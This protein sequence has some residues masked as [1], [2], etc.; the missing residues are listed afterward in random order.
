MSPRPL[1][2]SSEK[3]ETSA[4]NSRL[5]A[6]A[7]ATPKYEM[8]QADIEALGEAIFKNRAAEFD[9]MRGIYTNAGID[10]RYSCVELDWYA[11]EHSW[12]ERNNLYIENAVSLLRQSALAC[13]A[14]AGLEPADVDG[15]V[16]V[17]TTGVA[18]PSLD[19]LLMNELPFRNDLQRLPIFGLGCAGGVL[20]LGRAATLAKAQP[21]SHW[22]VLV[23][24]LCG[25]TF[26]NQDK[27]KSNIVA[28][29]LF[30][31]GAAAALISSAGDGPEI[32]NSGEH[33]WPGTLD[34][35]GW[36]LKDDGF[37]V[38]FHRD[39]PDLVRRDM[40]GAVLDFLNRTGLTLS[41]IDHFV[42]HPGG[43]KVIDA[44]QDAFETLPGAFDD[45]R[46]VLRDFGNMS[47]VTVLF[48]LERTLKRGAEGRFLLSA[49]GPGFTA[50]F[51]TMTRNPTP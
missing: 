6:L 38:L 42:A 26:R 48:V 29:A 51:L 23:V 34:V 17:S 35:M 40:R 13:L 22:M 31:D 27:S 21:G 24:E 41:D 14:R 43:A 37:G 18:T 33:T 19:A 49:L 5:I 11:R 28:T 50:G 2:S 4:P 39:I 16:T 10:T 25:L 8:R 1:S 20:G 36:R 12:T 15:L 47:A 7:S 45:A 46:S 3:I 9:R 32:E 44:M 30:G